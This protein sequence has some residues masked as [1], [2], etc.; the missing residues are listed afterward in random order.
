[1]AVEKLLSIDTTP[2]DKAVVVNVSTGGQP[3][4][5]V[6][7]ARIEG[8]TLT[9][10]NDRTTTKRFSAPYNEVLI[11]GNTYA[12][13]EEA[14]AALKEIGNFNLSSSSGGGGGD[15][16]PATSLPKEDTQNGA[17]G[18]SVRYA[19]ED[20]SHPR[21]WQQYLPLSGNSTSNPITGRIQFVYP[22]GDSGSGYI[23]MS[24][25]RYTGVNIVTEDCGL[26]LQPSKGVNII[27]REGVNIEPSNYGDVTIQPTR[28]QIFLWARGTDTSANPN[29]ITLRAAGNIDMYTGTA[30]AKVR[31][32]EVEVLTGAGGILTGLLVANAG[33]TVNGVLDMGPDAK[34]AFNESTIP[35]LSDYVT[36]QVE[37]YENEIVNPRTGQVIP[38]YAH[39][40]KGNTHLPLNLSH[41]NNELTGK[42]IAYDVGASWNDPDNFPALSKQVLATFTE[43][44]LQL[45]TNFFNPVPDGSGG[46]TIEGITLQQLNVLAFMYGLGLYPVAK[47]QSV[48][49]FRVT[50][51]S[52]NDSVA[53][54]DYNFTKVNGDT[55]E[56]YVVSVT[57]TD[58]AVRTLRCDRVVWQIG[59]LPVPYY[60][61]YG[62]G[63]ETK[64]T[65]LD[66]G[67]NLVISYKDATS[68][69]AS[70]VAE[71][72]DISVLNMY[73]TSL[74]NGVPEGQVFQAQTI[75]KTPVVVDETVYTSF[76]DKG[77]LNIIV[78]GA[79]YVLTYIVG[80]GF[81]IGEVKKIHA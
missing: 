44:V 78:Q 35:G 59:Q 7:S 41:G 52:I 39:V 12:T 75:G 22:G 8:D 1:M 20:H 38:V 13:P 18:T 48:L 32:N 27:P 68:A 71:N 6:Y 5:A 25:N 46:Y 29:P 4:H 24:S 74:Y 70:V 30:A 60:L 67:I 34:I 53:Y 50:R 63:I 56:R 58:A 64:I 10:I 14:I 65:I 11:N 3:E 62:N 45:P 31:I 81:A 2:D 17:V 16:E 66:S 73:R 69:S 21:A 61:S 37:V 76:N 49:T 54:F 47:D 42:Y 80:N 36:D 28:G 9:I 40:D 43:G 57:G 72:T 55:V 79:M 23:N 15:I 33:L 77:E 19:R 26:T 51:L